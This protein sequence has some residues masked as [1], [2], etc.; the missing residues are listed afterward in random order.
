MV[1]FVEMNCVPWENEA[2]IQHLSIMRK[3]KI[4]FQ[5]N[6]VLL[7][8]Y[9][10]KSLVNTLYRIRQ[11]SGKMMWVYLDC[12]LAMKSNTLS[13]KS[14]NFDILSGVHLISYAIW[15]PWFWSNSAA[16]PLHFSLP[17]QRLFYFERSLSI[18]SSLFFRLFLWHN[19]FT[20]LLVIWFHIWEIPA[21]WFLL[22]V[23]HVG[24]RRRPG[25]MNTFVRFVSTHPT[26]LVSKHSKTVEM[27]HMLSCKWYEFAMSWWLFWLDVVLYEQ[28]GI[29]IRCNMYCVLNEC[30]HDEWMGPVCARILTLST[31]SL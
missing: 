17:C 30:I 1:S 18:C 29:W 22:L 25:V 2:V 15:R 13:G 7:K 21:L 12:F 3:H 24:S 11:H 27:V 31:I 14:I 10:N 28:P 8:I 19:V 5:C 20:C 26:R 23:I 6:K 16:F 4:L 9:S